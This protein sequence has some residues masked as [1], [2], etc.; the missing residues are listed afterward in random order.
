MRNAQ[1]QEVLLSRHG[2]ILSNLDKQSV[3]QFDILDT[4]ATVQSGMAT[5]QTDIAK[6]SS[7]LTKLTVALIVLT[8]V[9][10]IREFYDFLC[11][12]F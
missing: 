12:L 8:A 11:W 10:A 7:R 1:R 5:V 2:S 3:R 6:D 4:M 9:L